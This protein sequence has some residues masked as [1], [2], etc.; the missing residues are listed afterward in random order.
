[1]THHGSGP[2]VMSS[3]LTSPASYWL[4]PW[5]LPMSAVFCYAKCNEDLFSL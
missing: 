2:A 5:Q 3:G 4:E 1:L